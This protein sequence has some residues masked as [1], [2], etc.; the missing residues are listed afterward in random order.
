MD[1]LQTGNHGVGRLEPQALCHQRH[2]FIRDDVLAAFTVEIARH[3]LDIH[4]VV[5][6]RCQH[7]AV[8]IGKLV[9]GA[10]ALGNIKRA[11]HGAIIPRTGR[12]MTRW[13]MQLHEQLR[14][15]IAQLG[16]EQR[17]DRVGI[18]GLVLFEV[19][20]HGPAHPVKLRGENRDP[21]ARFLPVTGGKR[22]DYMDIL[23]I[24][25][26]DPSAEIV[27]AIAA[28]AEGNSGH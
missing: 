11:R 26:T 7:L 18:E 2:H 25:Q 14:Q 13:V 10:W 24:Q 20:V 27:A 3:P 16:F 21:L 28:G 19:G 22:H 12:R 8:G 23:A 4:F 15:A 6:R 5:A 1:V 9:I 17:L